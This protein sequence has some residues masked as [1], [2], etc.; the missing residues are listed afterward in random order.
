MQEKNVMPY[1]IWENVP[2]KAIADSDS[3]SVRSSLLVYEENDIEVNYVNEGR[4][5]GKSNP[6]RRL[7]R[8]ALSVS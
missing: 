4:M 8:F 1:C 6:F 2:E 5:P 3:A 7:V